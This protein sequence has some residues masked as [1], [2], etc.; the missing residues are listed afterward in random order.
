LDLRRKTPLPAGTNTDTSPPRLMRGT[1]NPLD[2]T[3]AVPQ[4]TPPLAPGL[5]LPSLSKISNV[6]NSSTNA[7]LSEEYS[8]E[9]ELIGRQIGMLVHLMQVASAA[10]AAEAA[11]AAAAASAGSNSSSGAALGPEAAAGSGRDGSSSGSKESG[12]LASNSSQNGGGGA[13]AVLRR[14]SSNGARTHKAQLSAEVLEA[15]TQLL[16]IQVGASVGISH[17]SWP[18]VCMSVCR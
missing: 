10:E 14:Y 11:K 2:T 18:G 9:A 6:S 12:A 1:G 8:T 13:A 17:R 3:S 5:Q 16:C 4:L 15:A 7:S